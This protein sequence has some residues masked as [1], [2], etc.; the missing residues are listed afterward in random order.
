MKVSGFTLNVLATFR[1]L[2]RD[3]V[4]AESEEV[5]P[6]PLGFEEKGMLWLKERMPW[7]YRSLFGVR[8]H[9][10]LDC[11]LFWLRIMFL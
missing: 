11:G 4:E 10:S 3:Q 2:S 8:F 5:S 6:R 9:L 7:T 1:C